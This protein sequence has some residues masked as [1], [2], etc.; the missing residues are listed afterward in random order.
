[1]DDYPSNSRRLTTGRIISPQNKLKERKVI[2]QVTKGQIIKREKPL[3]IRMFGENTNSIGNYI[4]WDVLI[5][6]AKNTITAIISDGIEMLMYGEP[7]KGGNIR[8][9]RERSYVSYSGFYKDREHVHTDRISI[10]KS[11]HRFD[12]IVLDRRSDAEE[13]LSNLVDLIDDYGIASVGDFYDLVGIDQEWADNK[14]GWDNLSRASIRRVRE[15]YILE[16]P[17]PLPID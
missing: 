4:L 14:Y 3:L 2:Q 9:D 8:R 5:P 6:A 1:M 12:E 17:K 7:R 10:N 11:R 16:M 15:G 13:V